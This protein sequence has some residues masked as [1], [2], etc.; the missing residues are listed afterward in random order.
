M[1][2]DFNQANDA[3]SDLVE[4]ISVAD[5]ATLDINY[6]IPSDSI[7]TSDVNINDIEKNVTDT[8]SITDAGGTIWVDSYFENGRYSASPYV[9]GDYV[10]TGYSL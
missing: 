5:T 9:A 3:S 10:G 8:Q 1:V 6:V 4:N 7:T 2:R